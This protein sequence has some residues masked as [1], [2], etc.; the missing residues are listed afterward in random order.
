[1]ASEAEAAILSQQLF[2]TVD[3]IQSLQSVTPLVTLS[4][5]LQDCRLVLMVLAILDTQVPFP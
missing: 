4:M 3:M 2:A 5:V 1:M